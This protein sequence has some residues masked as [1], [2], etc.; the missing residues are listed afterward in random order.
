M[1]FMYDYAP[2]GED[3]LTVKGVGL[4]KNIMLKVKGSQLTK[5]DYNPYDYTEGATW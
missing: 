5:T 3:A 1:L 4:A 2:Q